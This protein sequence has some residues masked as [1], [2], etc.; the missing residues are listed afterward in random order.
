MG[1]LNYVS[2]YKGVQE[3]LDT[4]LIFSW[5][6]LLKLDV[7]IGYGKHGIDARTSLA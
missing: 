2:K 5:H 7:K 1:T 3:Y 6:D 4:I